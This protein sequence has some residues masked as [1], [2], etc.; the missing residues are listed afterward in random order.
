M[1][2]VAARVDA[3]CIAALE[4]RR[5]AEFWAEAL[6]WRV[7]DPSAVEIDLVPLD[8]TACRVRI[9]PTDVPKAVRNRHHFDL[10]TS[11][12]GDQVHTVGRLMVI[13]ARPADVGQRGDEGH[14]VLADPEGNEFCVLEPENNF[15][16]GAGRLGAINCDGLR[17]TGVFWQA[18]LGWPMVWDQDE[19]TAVRTPDGPGPLITWSG[20]PLLAKSGANRLFLDL[21]ADDGA[22][23]QA[24]ADR[25]V[26]L[27]AT[28]VDRGR[29]AGHILLAD[30]DGNEFRLR[31]V[32]G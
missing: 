17:A 11:D 23:V 21:V 27:G 2:L 28:R 12:R 3:V 29:T 30:P 32:A 13:G 6:R 24:E 14:I 25:I 18:V 31:R 7:D 4:P 1:I 22:D 10:T 8:G 19:E 26:G 20:P 5:L 15:L 9:V 16:A